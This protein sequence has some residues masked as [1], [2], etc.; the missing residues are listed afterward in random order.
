MAALPDVLSLAGR[1]AAVTG[2]GRGIGAATA[3]ALARAGACVAI[4]DRDAAGVTQTAEQIGLGGG[5]ALPFTTD[6]T[7]AFAVERTFDR[8]A[9]EWGR[10]DILVNNAGALREAP[11]EDVSDEDLQEM[12]DVNLRGVMVCTRSAVPHM[13]RNRHGRILS[14]SSVSTRLGASGLTAYSAAKAGIVGMTRTWARELGPLGITANCVAPGM[15][16]SETARTVPAAVLASTLAR[17]PAGRLGTPDEVANVYVFLA[18]E[19]A[20]FVNGAVVGVD[21]GLLLY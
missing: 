10:F 17:I 4:L 12:L 15:I 6:I 20:S 19:L 21:G 14:A 5:E 11:L 9:E 16:D 2:A 1:V 3:R 18:S 7:D 13:A 8:V